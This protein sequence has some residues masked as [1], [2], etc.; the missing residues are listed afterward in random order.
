MIGTV[1]LTAKALPWWRKDGEQRP[2]D[3]M[4]DEKFLRFCRGESHTHKDNYR[5]LQ[6]IFRYICAKDAEFSPASP[7]AL[8][9]I[10]DKDLP[11]HVQTKYQDLQ[12]ALRAAKLLPSSHVTTTTGAS[13]NQGVLQ[14]VKLSK[15]VRQSQQPGV[16]TY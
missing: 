4:T 10:S 12:K 16:S 15:G 5:G 11:D 7:K 9:A 6:T 1:K 2:V 3:I 8:H 13:E 14:D